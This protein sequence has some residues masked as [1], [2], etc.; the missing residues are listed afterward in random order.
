MLSEALAKGMS[1][2]IA[3]PTLQVDTKDDVFTITAE[4]S[5]SVTGPVAYRWTLAPVDPDPDNPTFLSLTPANVDGSA[6]SVD[7]KEMKDKNIDQARVTASVIIGQMM[8]PPAEK[9]LGEAATEEDPADTEPEETE[10]EGTDS[11]EVEPK[12]AQDDPN[13]TVSAPPKS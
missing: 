1:T 13:V 6:I 5:P 3:A 12:P 4:L 11:D 2:C 10:P 9:V 8:S 7:R